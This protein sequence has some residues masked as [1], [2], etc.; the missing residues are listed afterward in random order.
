MTD[1]Y[2][3]QWS[4]PSSLREP[5]P[6][7]FLPVQGATSR[8]P[9]APAGVPKDSAQDAPAPPASKEVPQF[10]LLSPANFRS[11]YLD[12]KGA[13]AR[14]HLANERTFLAWLRTSLLFVL[15]GIG[16]TQLFRLVEPE[17]SEDPLASRHT[18]KAVGKVL[19]TLFIG[20][21]ILLLLF[22]F[23][24]YFE[25]QYLLQHNYYPATRIGVVALVSLVFALVVATFAAV[26]YTYN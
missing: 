8:H 12:N 18:A 14:D 4:L 22:G 3:S 17:Q 20:V 6:V 16:L 11:V 23:V 2:G 19:G 15:I 24:R 5:S 7:P 1:Q 9:A 10:S 21:G 13:V 26:F 25:V